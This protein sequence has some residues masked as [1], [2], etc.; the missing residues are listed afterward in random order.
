[1]QFLNQPLSL[2]TQK[3]GDTLLHDL[4]KGKTVLWMIPGGSNISVAVA[5][6][7]RLIGHETKLVITLCDERYGPVGHKD[8]NWQQLLQTGFKPGSATCYPVL[9]EGLSLAATSRM[10]ELTLQDCFEKADSVVSFL[11]M[12]S[13]GHTSG[14]LPRSSAAADISDLVTYYQT[15]QYDRITTTFT[16]LKKATTTFCLAYGADKKAALGQ[17]KSKQLTITEQPIQILK[18]LPAAYLYNDEIGDK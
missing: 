8:S 7:K 4:K 13:D 16:A 2:A 17:L 6:M 1:M 14:I 10:F 9:Q 15:E 12:G 18:L 11:G 3:L 5:V